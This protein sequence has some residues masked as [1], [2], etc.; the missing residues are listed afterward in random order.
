VIAGWAWVVMGGSANVRH[1]RA[2][3]FRVAVF[4]D[5]GG[6]IISVQWLVC[7]R[8]LSNKLCVRQG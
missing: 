8:Y 2:T 6:G 5:G 3:V 4:M 7:G 1:R